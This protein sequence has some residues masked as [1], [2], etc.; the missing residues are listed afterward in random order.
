VRALEA[1]HATSPQA[2]GAD[3]GA[4]RSQCAPRLSAAAFHALLR[5]EPRIEITGSAAR[6]RRHV[7]TDNPG[8]QKLWA[9]VQ[10]PMQAAGF[11]GLTIAELAAAA[12]V[13]E[14]EL[15]DFLFR[16]AK[17]G[18]V[19][20]VSVERFYLRATLARFASIALAVSRSV[21]AGRFAAAQMR[22]RTGIGRNR[23]IEILEC[24]DRLGL[25]RRAGDLRTMAKDYTTVFGEPG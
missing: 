7:P 19:V 5:E 11:N 2:I 9:R 23:V 8:D 20:K 15:K 13:K 4:L 6:L 1:F 22:D 12:R 16:K 21:P 18:E 24:F 14:A 17:S 3:L 25:T 10:P